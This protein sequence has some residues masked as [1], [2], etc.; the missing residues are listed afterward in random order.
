VTPPISSRRG[1]AARL[2]AL[3]VVAALIPAPAAGQVGVVVSAYTD[4]RFRGYS[5]SDGRPVGILDVAYDAPNGVYA[6]VSGSVVAA[7]DDGLKGLGLALNGGYA[8]QIRHGLTLDL[9]VIH[10][11]Y[12]EYSGLTTGRTYSEA[13]AG[14]AGKFLGTRFSISPDYI[15]PAHWTVHGEI[16]GHVDLTRD[17]LLD[18]TLGAL[19]PLGKGGYKG[20]A[21]AQWD[22]RVGVA[23]RLGPV[24]LHAALT[25][26]GKS[27]RTYVNQVHGRAAIVLGVST[28][29]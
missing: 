12:S 20:A 28:A 11:R 6:A 25:G 1:F 15:G 10:S 2:R 3:L 13:Y 7:R 19:I 5:L 4:Q 29:L 9:G 14:I 24:L 22:A 23:Q 8:R 18:G 21:R 17:L 27:S 26:R 16:N